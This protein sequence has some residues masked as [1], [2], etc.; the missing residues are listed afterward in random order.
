MEVVPE[1]FWQ[2]VKE[3]NQGEFYA[4]HDTLEALWL[5]STEPQKSFY[6]GILQISVACYHLGNENWQG[7]VTLLG[8]GIRRLAS[9]QPVYAQ[10]DVTGM[11]EQSSNLL[12]HLQQTGPKQVQTFSQLVKSGDSSHLEAAVCLD[13]TTE[14]AKLPTLVKLGS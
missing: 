3:F 6:Q 8:E 12:T 10:I 9:Y 1:S 11:V 5:E 14:G 13:G 4:C 2:G 7:A